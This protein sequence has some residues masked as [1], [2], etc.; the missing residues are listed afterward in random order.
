MKKI[1]KIIFI[2][3]TILIAITIFY[4]SSIP[5]E[6][7][8]TPNTIINLSTV[9]HFGIF[10]LLTLFLILS[11]T[12]KKL[13]TKQFIIILSIVIIYAISDE[14]HQIFIPNRFASIKDIITD[15][16]GGLCSLTFYSGI[17]TFF[18]STE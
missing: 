12:N 16:I 5:G 11:T 15:S 17:Q 7:I 8:N 10:A 9:Y 3:I 13:T 6:E 4:M 2:T 1:L 14:I 18:K